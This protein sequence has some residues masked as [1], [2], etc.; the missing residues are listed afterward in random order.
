MATFITDPQA[1]LWAQMEEWDLICLGYLSF[2][3]FDIPQ[4]R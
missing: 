3:S 2:G 1:G 4:L